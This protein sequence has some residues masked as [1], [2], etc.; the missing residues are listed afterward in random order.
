[1]R[2]AVKSLLLAFTTLIAGTVAYAQVTT[3]SLAGEVTEEGQGPLAGATVVAVHQPSG[4]QYYAVTNETGRYTINGMRS[5]GPYNV[6]VSFMGMNT[7]EYNTLYLKLG[8]TFELNAT[9][10]SN[11]QL[12]ASTV[13]GQASFNASITGA[14]Q[15]F[16]LGTVENTPKIDRSV[17]DVVK[18]TPQATVNKN[19]GISFAGSNNRYNSFQIDGA[20]SNDTF[21][22]AASPAAATLSPSTQLTRSR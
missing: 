4:S 3:S 12:A 1:M 11:E 14:G 22:L 10:S 20:I 19:G 7:V 21:G 5:G 8:E 13:V 15:S 18:F 9:L 6:Q 16:G 2:K 17:Y